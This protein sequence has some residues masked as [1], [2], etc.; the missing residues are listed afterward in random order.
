MI[1]TLGI[2]IDKIWTRQTM[3]GNGNLIVVI[4]YKN[5]VG[6]LLYQGGIDGFKFTWRTGKSKE[7]HILKMEIIIN[8]VILYVLE[9]VCERDDLLLSYHPNY[10]EGAALQDEIG[11]VV[12]TMNNQKITSTYVRTP[13]INVAE[14]TNVIEYNDDF[15]KI[16]YPKSDI[17]FTK[18]YFR[19]NY[20]KLI[21]MFKESIYINKIIYFRIRFYCENESSMR[22]HLGVDGF[23]KIWINSTV[24]GNYF[25]RV[26]PLVPYAITK[27]FKCSVG[28]NEI[29]IAIKSKRKETYGV[30]CYL[31][32]VVK[33]RIVEDNYMLYTE[34]IPVAI[35]GGKSLCQEL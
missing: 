13:Y 10:C 15:A 22:F 11:N 16:E 34:Y 23:A 25:K 20:C 26:L 2:E 14:I 5:V 24:M 9:S 29:L 28:E 18:T 30:L 3:D 32:K 27:E 1:S 35:Y 19:G 17:I 8:K 31:E 7:I 33:E 21:D 6:S 4:K 12:P